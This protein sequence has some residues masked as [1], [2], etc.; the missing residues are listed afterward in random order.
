MGVAICRLRS[1]VAMPMVFVPKS[2]PIRR[3]VW[4]RFSKADWRLRRWVDM[5]F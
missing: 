1:L 4:G 3:E 5:G 2:S